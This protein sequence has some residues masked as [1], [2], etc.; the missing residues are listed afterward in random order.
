MKSPTGY[1]TRCQFKGVVPPQGFTLVELLVVI[2]IIGVLVALLLPAV[3]AARESA[4]RTQCVNNLKQFGVA[5]HNYHDAKKKLPPGRLGCDGEGIDECDGFTN[6]QKSGMSAFVMLLPYLEESA[7]HDLA[8]YERPIWPRTTSW[9]TP[10]H[11]RLIESRPAVMVCP[12]D[13]ALPFADDPVYGPANST[14]YT[15]PATAKAAVGSYATVMGR[16]G[17]A[18]EGLGPEYELVP[19]KYRNSGLFFYIKRLSFTKVPDGLSKTF[20][21]GEVTE[22]NTANGL[23]IWTRAIR[24]VDTQ[25]T[26]DNP[27]NTRPG[28]PEVSTRHG[29]TVNGAFS[30]LH[31]GGCQF[32]FGDGHVAMIVETIDQNIYEAMSTREGGE[33]VPSI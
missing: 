12:T 13:I 1:S 23:N 22:G 11:L 29:R 3:Q 20:M 30:S 2:A 21:V 9:W 25:R 5:I 16:F 33:T 24:A 6:A 18:N 17:I 14:V 8:D 27:V 10:N 19:S 32:V 4:R 15:I 31:P 7:L 26:T 28:S